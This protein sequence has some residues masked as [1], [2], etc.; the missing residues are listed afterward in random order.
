MVD[1]VV[2][3]AAW[4]GASTLASAALL[5]FLS[6]G[7]SLVLFVVALRHLGTARTGA[8]FSVAPFFGALLGVLMLG[9]PV[10]TMLLVAGV[11]MALGVWL[12][13]TEQHGHLHT[14]EPVEHSHEHVHDEHHRHSHEGDMASTG[15]HSHPH[16]HVATTHSHAHYPDAHHRHTH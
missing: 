2:A 8:Y 13:L 16:V 9:E 11:L 5:G 7:A 12:H 6:Y 14:H 10:T 15:S 1:V 4:P 3:R